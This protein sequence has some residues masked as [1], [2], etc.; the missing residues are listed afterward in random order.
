MSLELRMGNEETS[1]KDSM[2]GVVCSVR[3]VWFERLL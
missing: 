1:G 2:Q 3:D